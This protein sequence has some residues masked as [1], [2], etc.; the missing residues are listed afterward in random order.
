MWKPQ[1]EQPSL[2]QLELV[3][4]SELWKV[5]S[6][7]EYDSNWQHAGHIGEVTLGIASINNMR[8]VANPRAVCPR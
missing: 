1:Q 4:C 8:A 3:L 2:S 7:E 6:R 5:K